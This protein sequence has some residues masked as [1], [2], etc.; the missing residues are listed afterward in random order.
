MSDKTRN[1]GAGLTLDEM[2]VYAMER[3]AM[4]MMRYIC[5]LTFP[6]YFDAPCS[7]FDIPSPGSHDW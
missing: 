4:L 5:V 2:V 7:L 3:V 6:S 1:E